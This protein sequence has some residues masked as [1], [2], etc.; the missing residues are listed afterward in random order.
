MTKKSTKRRTQIESSGA[1]VRKP[2]DLRVISLG[3][4]LQSTTI[5]LMS[6]VGYIDRADHAIFADPG[7]EHPKTYEIMNWLMKWQEK[8]GGIP[9]HWKK[10]SLLRDLLEKHNSTN[11][12]L[13]S[14]P[15]FTHDGSGKLRR[16]CTKE[17]KI[18]VVVKKIRQLYGLEPRK[19]MPMTELWLGIS[20]DEAHRMKESRLP[21]IRNKYPLI[22]LGWRRSDC[23]AWLEKNNF[24]IP[25]KSACVFCPYQGD[26]RW[27]QLKN[28]YPNTFETAVEVDQSIRDSTKQGI[29]EKIYLH[30]QCLPLNQIDFDSQ[31][32]LFGEECDGFCDV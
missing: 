17:Y 12:R 27:K 7:A 30:R 28:R 10:K 9:L 15:A 3:A 4:G 31:I 14:I 11:H 26:S 22:D 18:D 20:A 25:N 8:N 24:P 21:R 5:Y 29:L 1:G 23:R 2:T 19:R 16:Q 6:S 32:D 13:A